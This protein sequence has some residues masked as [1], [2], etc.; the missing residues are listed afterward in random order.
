[1]NKGIT[2][3]VGGRH[4]TRAGYVAE[5]TAFDENPFRVFPWRGTIQ[6][7]P[8]FEKVSW[9]LRGRGT[10]DYTDD[11]IDLMEELT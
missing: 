3:K 7:G 8:R 2:L 4:K 9:T 10:G 5:I 6:I 11:P 1:M